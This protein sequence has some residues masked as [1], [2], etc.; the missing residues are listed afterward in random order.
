[1]KSLYWR[2]LLWLCAINVVTL[3]VS[4]GVSN[5][6]AW[7]SYG[8]ATDWLALA[9]EADE[10]YIADGVQ[11]FA[12]WVLARHHDV[13]IDATLFE[14]GDSLLGGPLLPE[15]RS[16]LPQ[17]LAAEHLV[18]RLD[19]QRLAIGERVIG[20]DGIERHFVALR[21]A[22]P[23]HQR[24]GTLLA[25]Q[26]SLSLLA[27]GVVG[28]RLA[29]SVAAPVTALQ[30]T[31]QRMADGE[32]SARV[33]AAHLATGD[34]LGLLARE[35]D[36]M[37]AR[38]EALVTSQRRLLQDVSHELRSP[39]AR[40][41]LILEL[42]QRERGAAA[43]AQLAGAQQ[44]IIRLD[45][46]IGEL[47]ALSRADAG[48][49]ALEW[50]PVELAALARERLALAELEARRCGCTLQLQADAPATVRGDARLL[51][52]ALDNLLGNA[53]KFGAGSAVEVFVAR[54]GGRCELGVRDRGPGVPA[55]ELAQLFR[56][57]FRGRNA[58]A[59]QG[60]GLGLAI[61]ERVARAHGGR[62]EARSEPGGGLCVSLSLPAAG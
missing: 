2:L 26:L 52:R 34:E 8:R 30:R 29:R 37:A 32:L 35:F 59:A 43:A 7:Y 60:Y 19:P 62:V 27:I 10:R 22:E 58:D 45:R 3:L 24:R 49:A 16:V 25:L 5:A 36:R 14:A 47:L 53:L 55:A 38:V 46:L 28:R 56:P 17:L 12:D 41:Q 9:H 42:A 39:L 57:F 31:A 23:F 40:L 4:V 20:S 48:L 18:L 13:R 61:V 15:L 50:R 11:G 33:D 1:M 44:E 21:G 54:A 6:I 51:A